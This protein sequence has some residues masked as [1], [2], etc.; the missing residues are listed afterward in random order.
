MFYIQERSLL[1]DVIIMLKTAQT[2]LPR[3]GS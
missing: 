3:P 2:V 1:L